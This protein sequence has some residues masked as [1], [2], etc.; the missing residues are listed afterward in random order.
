MLNRLQQKVEKTTRFLGTAGAVSAFAML[1]MF[2]SSA[3]AQTAGEAPLRASDDGIQQIIVTANK[4]AES[5]NNVSTAI[6]A[7]GRD[8]LRN[9]N[10][11]DIKDL[12]ILA[13]SLTI[14]EVFDI[15]QIYIRGIG[16]NVQNPG[17][18]S[19]V[20]VYTDGAPIERQEAQLTSLFDLERVEVL[21]GPQGTLY[22]RNAI[23][24]AVNYITAKPSDTLEGYARFTYGN[25][26]ANQLEAAVGGPINDWLK[27]R[28]AFKMINRGGFG[29]NIVSGN[30]INDEHREM[31][32]LS[33]IIE[34]SDKFSAFL[35]GEFYHQDD[36]AGVLTIDGGAQI[37]PVTGLQ[38]T[39]AG[40]IDPTTGE[41]ARVPV[42]LGGFASNPRDTAEP[43]DPYN[44]KDRWSVT[45]QFDW[46]LND[47]LKITSI[48][49]IQSIVSW[50]SEYQAKS[51]VFYYKA[52]SPLTRRIGDEPQ[53]STELQFKV[54]TKWISGILGASY[55]Q[56]RQTENQSLGS[57][58]RFSNI[59]SSATGD[60]LLANGYDPVA[61]IGFCK[62]IGQMILSNPGLPNNPAR[63]CGWGRQNVKAIGLYGHAD[64]GLGVFGDSLSQFT[65]KLGARYSHQSNDVYNPFTLFGLSPTFDDDPTVGNITSFDWFMP[66]DRHNSGKFNDFSPEI[67]LEWR[68]APGYLM[69]Y[70]YSEG[71]KAGTGLTVPGNTNLAGPEKIK[72]HEIGFKGSFAD[73]RLQLNLSAFTYHLYGAQFQRSFPGPIAGFISVFENAA[74]TKASGA[75]IDLQAI[76]YR[77]DHVKVQLSSNLIYQH[78]RFVDYETVDPADPRLFNSS[79]PNSAL[80]QNLRGNPTRN[81]PDWSGAARLAIEFRSLGLP[82][83]GTLTWSG[84]VHYQSRSYLTEFKKLVEST[85]AHTILGSQLAYRNRNGIS[86]SAWVKNLTDEMY[87]TGVTYINAAGSTR[88]VSL[89][90]PRTYGLTVGYDF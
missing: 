69:Y 65:L 25:Y 61:V 42:G 38:T 56:E 19:G 86:V 84:N 8:E 27:A 45:A 80:L 20:A 34:P 26:K 67:G 55:F 51:S 35:S 76:P 54:N 16:T 9:A 41:F 64:V 46:N 60:Y 88:E 33:L 52:T 59:R 12:Q 48:N 71:F 53:A 2:P 31:G 18:S 85:G 14:T 39:T 29:K 68:P 58:G 90:P 5:I 40:I 66:E 87:K 24:G 43:L 17:A 70:T 37:D 77:S 21:S 28:V 6:S 83:D 15:A 74:D 4:R 30:P 13:P 22:G 75:E 11:N 1:A 72:N 3:I 47:W 50:T 49:N 23:G 89:F 10:I 82:G 81:A 79:L 36:A 57:D 7:F 44:R 62:Q 63:I 73:H 32:R 78:S